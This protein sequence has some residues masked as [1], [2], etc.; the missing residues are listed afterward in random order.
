MAR[1]I[2]ASKSTLLQPGPPEV[3]LEPDE[4]GP[5]WREVATQ[6]PPAGLPYIPGIDG[7]RAL[8]VLAVLVY[9][10][11]PSWL[12]GG[13]L[14]VEVFFVISGFLITSLLLERRGAAGGGIGA[15]WLSR[16]RRLLPAVAVMIAAVVAY[17]VV[18]LPKEVAALRQDAVAAAGYATNWYLIFDQQSYFESFG[19]PS[20]LRHLWSLAVEEQFYIVWPLLLALGLRFLPRKA[21]PVLIIAVAAGLAALMATLYVYGAGESRLYYGT[22]TRAAGL[23]LGSTLAFVLR[24]GDASLPQGRAAR[25]S[26]EGLG[27]AALAALVALHVLLAD[28]APLLYL[29]GLAIVD[30]AAVALIVAVAWPRGRLGWLFGLAPLRWLG[31]RSYGVYLWHWPVFMLTRPGV[32][33]PL[34]G[35]ELLALRLGVTLALAEVSYRL[36]E[37]P[38]RRGAI[39]RAW[40]DVRGALARRRPSWRA[41]VPAAGLAGA[42]AAAAVLAVFVRDAGSPEAPPYLAAGRL[43]AGPWQPDR[44]GALAEPFELPPATATAAPTEV[45]P[46]APAPPTAAQRVAGGPP[47]LAVAAVDQPTATQPAPMVAARATAIGDSVMLGAVGELSGAVG[48]ISIDAAVNRQV[49]VGI[50]LLRSWKASGQLGDVVVVHLGNNG[51]FT[52]AQFDQVMAVLA[53]RRVVIFVNVRVPREW[54]GK[55]NNTIA[56][57]VSRYANAR[58]VDWHAWSASRPDAFYDDATHVKPEGAGLYAA[59]IASALR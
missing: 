51:T 24:P 27:L 13:F 20:L 59:L 25:W 47:A 1:R 42:I 41:A 50:D 53:D 33:L 39:G 28:D 44:A 8:A 37:M 52:P 10:A 22:D 54:E 46:T 6:W 4:S 19:R 15:F 55:N 48:G 32:D 9:H 16:A 7:L 38:A 36:I 14:G 23:L 34:D 26:I 45:P 43:Q 5:V 2:A 30:V 40:A 58:L 31:T 49:S 56:D 17:A 3:A 57:G 29:G 11:E 18:A 12:P 35:A 21:L